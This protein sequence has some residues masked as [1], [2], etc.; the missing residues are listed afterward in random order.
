MLWCMDI[1]TPPPIPREF[2]ELTDVSSMLGL[3]RKLMRY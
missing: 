2:D 3:T 1:P